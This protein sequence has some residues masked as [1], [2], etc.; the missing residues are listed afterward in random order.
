MTATF[1]KTGFSNSS[2]ILQ[3]LAT[4]R[5]SLVIPEVLNKIS[6]VLDSLT[7]ESYKLYTSL[8]YMEA[9]AGPMTEGS[10]N[11]NKGINQNI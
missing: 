1:C 5:P 8:S 3:H 11:V 7:T 4:M 10:R 2:Q 9:I 6:T